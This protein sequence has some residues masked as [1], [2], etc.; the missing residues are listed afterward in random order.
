M[1]HQFLF[2]SPF[3]FPINVPLT[4][5]PHFR[6]PF[7]SPHCRPL[8]SISSFPFPHSYLT[9]P[10][11]LFLSSH[12]VTPLLSPYFPSFIFPVHNLV[13]P[14]SSHSRLPIFSSPLSSLFPSPSPHFPS[15]TFSYFSLFSNHFLVFSLQPQFQVSIPQLLLLVSPL[16][17]SPTL[18]SNVE[19]PGTA[20]KR[21]TSPESQG[22]EARGLGKFQRSSASSRLALRS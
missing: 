21:C 13:L 22:G 17:S 11:P 12:P 15:P 20:K 3:P 9:I 5:S 7:S 10:I 2:H 8:K 19:A 18:R 6:V 4:L 14:F 1:S 16:Y